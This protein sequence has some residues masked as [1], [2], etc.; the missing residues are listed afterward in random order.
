MVFTRNQ[1]RAAEQAQDDADFG[2]AP[3]AGGNRF[4]DV[5]DEGGHVTYRRAHDNEQAPAAGDARYRQHLQECIDGLYDDEEEEEHDYSNYRN[6]QDS[7]DEDSDEDS[8]EETVLD[9]AV[10]MVLE[11]EPDEPAPA[12]MEEEPEQPV[13]EPPPQQQQAVPGGRAGGRGRGGRTGGRAG[14]RG[15]GGRAGGRGRAGRGGQPAV[16]TA[17]LVLE[18]SVTLQ[19]MEDG[20]VDKG[21]YSRYCNEIIHLLTWINENE[22]TW[23]TEY[24]QGRYNELLVLQEGEN[25]NA[26]RKRIKEAWMEMLR[27]SRHKPIVHVGNITP[28][29]VLVGFISKQANQVTLKPLSPAGYGGKRTAVF[30]LMRCH[31][32][33]GPSQDF[34]DEMAALWKGFSRTTKKKKMRARRNADPDIDGDAAE[35]ESGSDVD[36]DEEDDD[37]DE[38]KEGKEPMSPELFRCVCKWLVEWGNSDGIFAALFIVLSWN[39]VCRGMNTAKIRLSHLKWSVFDTLQISRPAR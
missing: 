22:P 28:A 12:A 7:D 32:G 6:K 1:S 33:K 13:V 34:Q 10:A 38:F 29:R 30:H 39:L 21:V 19:E 18:N 16:I 27:N 26:R 35:T 5:Q 37:R 15:R 25:K 20:I 23:L 9:A 8:D 4:R 24:G 17:R 14:G 11:E 2:D 36:D 3:I 31:N